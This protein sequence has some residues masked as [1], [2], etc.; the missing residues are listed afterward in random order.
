MRVPLL[1]FHGSL[2]T[3]ATTDE[4]KSIQASILDRQG[5][6]E[7]VIYDDDTHGLMPHRDDIHKQV[8][9][10]LNRFEGSAGPAIGGNKA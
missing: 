4:L 10:F 5:E 3:S 8:L 9:K 6:C 1:I 2:D 7:L